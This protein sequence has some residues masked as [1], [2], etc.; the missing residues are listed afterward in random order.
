VIG[1]SDC[2]S[3]SDSPAPS[4]QVREELERFRV[5]LRK[6]GIRSRLRYTRSGN[7]FMVKRWVV[8]HSKDF[9]RAS[10]FA[11]EFLEQHH[12]TTRFIHNAA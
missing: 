1:S 2:G 7:A 4:D 11:A 12:H 9:M 3:W 5:V 8:V 6:H 10:T